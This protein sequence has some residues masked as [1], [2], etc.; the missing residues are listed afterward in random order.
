MHGLTLAQRVDQA[1]F[2]A[3]GVAPGETPTALAISWGKGDPHKDPIFLVYAD[4]KGE[5]RENIRLD[6]LV[7]EDNKEEYF[8]LLNQEYFNA[9]PIETDASENKSHDKILKFSDDK[10][11]VLV[12]DKKA[13]IEGE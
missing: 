4:E 6:N 9:L 3:F 13:N 1:P 8:N 7:D 12:F 11:C 2:K 10:D 5:M